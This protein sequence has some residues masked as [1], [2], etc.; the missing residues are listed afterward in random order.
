MTQQDR[1]IR[2]PCNAVTALNNARKFMLQYRTE[3]G[4]QPTLEEIAT[5]C[6]TPPATM[7]AYMRHIKE[8]GSL[9]SK[10]IQGSDETT[11]FIDFIA[12]PNSIDNDDYKLDLYDREVIFD[13]VDKLDRRSQ[14]VL[15][16]RYGFDGYHEHTYLELAKKTGFSRE[17]VRQ[18]EL[19]AVRKLRILMNSGTSLGKIAA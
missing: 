14:M 2:L 6:K 1:T 15:K 9:D 16:M 4:K 3:H 11:T 10:T 19:K 5:Y 8:C 13:Q 18:I 17:R 12:C 7:K